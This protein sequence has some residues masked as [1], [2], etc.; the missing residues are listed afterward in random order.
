MLYNLL[1]PINVTSL[2]TVLIIVAVIAI[3]FAI[4]IV[5]VSKLCF[6]KED[7]RI[8]KISENLAGANCGGCGYP[9]CQGLADAIVYDKVDPAKCRPCKAEVVAEIREYLKKHTG[10]NN[11]YIVPEDE[12]EKDS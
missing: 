10:P 6:V 3:I 5:T 8:E 9:G 2:L 1:K 11:E 7:E 12:Q 4:L